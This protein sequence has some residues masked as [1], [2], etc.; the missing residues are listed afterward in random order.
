MS[1]LTTQELDRIRGMDDAGLFEQIAARMQA[2]AENVAWLAA[3]IHELA[4]RQSDV[5]ERAADICKSGFWVYLPL[6][7]S[8]Q[9]SAS[10]VAAFCTREPL[11]ALVAQLPIA[12]QERL[13][14]ADAKFAVE[15]PNPRYGQAGQPEFDTRNYT[16]YLLP[17]HLFPQ[18]FDAAAR[19]VRDAPAQRAYLAGQKGKAKP[20]PRVKVPVLKVDAEH[21]LV[22][23]D[24]KPVRVSSLADALAQLAADRPE[25]EQMFRKAFR[26][27]KAAAATRNATV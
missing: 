5:A 8:G 25:V 22:Y 14:S 13:A 23:V 10:A 11:L 7:A 27:V 17:D 1:K 9:V 26:E 21:L 18:V 15:F 20:A 3:A 12:E 19:T 2:V 4:R 6:V 24:G 16:P